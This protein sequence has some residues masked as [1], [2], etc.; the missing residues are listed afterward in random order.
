MEYEDVL[1]M[2]IQCVVRWNQHIFQCLTYIIRHYN[3]S[4]SIIDLVSHTTYAVYINFM[5]KWTD[6]QFKVDSE[7]QI[8]FF[9]EKLFVEKLFTL[10]F[11]ARNPRRGKIFFCILF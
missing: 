5:H 1:I 2:K 6:L 7:R 9:F 4:A 8:F 11:F 3:P 10:K